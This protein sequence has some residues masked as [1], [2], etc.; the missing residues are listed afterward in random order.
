MAG[1][2]L[3]FEPGHGRGVGGIAF[4]KHGDGICLVSCGSDGKVAV[5]NPLTVAVQKS[6]AAGGPDSTSP[7]MCLAASPSGGQV[8][9]GGKDQIVKVCLQ[10]HD[11]I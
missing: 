8:A 1:A 11:E 4:A 2:T 5:R 3:K 7:L 9:T 6:H 10:Q